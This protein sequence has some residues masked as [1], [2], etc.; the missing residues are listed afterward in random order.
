MTRL[1]SRELLSGRFGYRLDA[2]WS[3]Y[4]WGTNLLDD[5][6]ELYLADGTNFGIPAAYGR[7]GD[8]RTVGV[9]VDLG[10]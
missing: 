3:V 7:V 1:S 8:P 5:D 9:G 6:Y 4:A 10:W 2:G